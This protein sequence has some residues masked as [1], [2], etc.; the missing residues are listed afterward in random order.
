[1]SELLLRLEFKEKNYEICRRLLPY[2]GSV[3]FYYA[4]VNTCGRIYQLRTNPNVVRVKFIPTFFYAN[5]VHA[6]NITKTDR[7][8]NDII[9]DFARK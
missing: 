6:Q 2:D 5:N 1:M 7:R 9:F 8:K 3:I 4:S